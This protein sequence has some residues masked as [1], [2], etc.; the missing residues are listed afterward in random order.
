MNFILYEFQKYVC[1]YV[2]VCNF[3][4][5]YQGMV[6]PDS[7]SSCHINWSPWHHHYSTCN[8]LVVFVFFILKIH[9]ISSHRYSTKKAMAFWHRLVQMVTY[10]YGPTIQPQ[11]NLSKF[12]IKMYCTQSLKC[13]IPVMVKYLSQVLSSSLPS[14]YHFVEIV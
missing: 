9:P 5:D 1:V 14:S 3:V 13:G 12:S 2:C 7:C 11:M 6:C 10:S 8:Q 4:L